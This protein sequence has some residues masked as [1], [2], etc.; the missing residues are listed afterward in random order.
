M[1]MIVS[2][3]SGPALNKET[4]VK[5]FNFYVVTVY[6]YIIDNAT[7]DLKILSQNEHGKESPS[8]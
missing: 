5:W 8:M 6:D 3:I 1:F 7:L 4:I 2:C